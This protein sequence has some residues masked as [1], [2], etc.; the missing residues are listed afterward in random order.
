M[1]TPETT[2]ET[3]PALALV[4]EMA[5]DRAHEI[6]LADGFEAALIGVVERCGMYPTALYDKDKCIGILVA[7]DGMTQDEAEEF[8]E[9][10]VLGAW[11]GAGTPCFATLPTP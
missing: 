3:T 4:H 1:T 11:V 5:F 6:L 10:N 7:R 9:F 8:F 2:P